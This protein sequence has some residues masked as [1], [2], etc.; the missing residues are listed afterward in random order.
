MFSLS[1]RASEQP[2][3]EEPPL[4]DS[5]M[6]KASDEQPSTSSGDPSSDTA[7]AMVGG[8]ASAS[9]GEGR[10]REEK[11]GGGRRKRGRRE[12]RRKNEKVKP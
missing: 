7:S 5:L 12:G 11:G 1:K 3:G 9:E 8:E 2:S 4:G 6:A 10:G